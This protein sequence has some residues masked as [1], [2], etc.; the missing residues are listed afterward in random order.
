VPPPLQW[1][2][3]GMTLGGVLS[4]E[5]TEF[6]ELQPLAAIDDPSERGWAAEWITAI[7]GRERIEVTPEAKVIYGPH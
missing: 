2:A 4:G 5:S 6:V 7:L 3:I 1:V